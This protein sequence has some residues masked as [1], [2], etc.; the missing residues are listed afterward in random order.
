VVLVGVDVE[1]EVVGVDVEVE[2]VLV[3]VE[4]EVVLVGVDVEV[5]VVLV[6]VDVEVEVVL[7][8]VDVEVV[9]VGGVMMLVVIE[10]LQ[11]T[12]PPPPLPEL[13]HW[14]TVTGSADVWVEGPTVHVTRIVPPPP[15]PELLHWVIVALVVLAGKGS[16][17]TVG[18]VPPPVPDPLHWLTVAPV[19]E[20]VPVM[21]LVIVTVHLTVLPPPSPV[22]LHWFTDVVS[23]PEVVVVGAAQVG[24]PAAPVHTCVV[25]VE[26]AT[27]VARLRL[28]MIVTVQST[29]WPPTLAMPLHWLTAADAGAAEVATT[30]AT[31]SPAENSA[32]RIATDAA[33][34]RIRLTALPLPEHTHKGSYNR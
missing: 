8:G 22:P 15:L 7:V 2:V 28:L 14:L 23:W 30:R 10:V 11:V 27:P 25:T 20:A 33:P 3:G 34:K 17:F 21:L 19:V 12:V 9:L 1:V 29:S 4:V 26:V 6:G 5:E 32:A 18:W 24:A 16:Q 13:L 31:I